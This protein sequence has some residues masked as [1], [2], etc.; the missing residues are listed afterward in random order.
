MR[1]KADFLK[2]K[3]T[4]CLTENHK[5]IV[6]LCS[7]GVELCGKHGYFHIAKRHVKFSVELFKES[8]RMYVEVRTRDCSMVEGLL[9]VLKCKVLAESLTQTSHKGTVCMHVFKVF[10][11]MARI[12]NHISKITIYYK[13]TECCICSL[14]ENM[15]LCVACG[16]IFCGRKRHNILGNEHGYK[17][18]E[19]TEHSLFIGLD[20]FDPKQLSIAAFC[21]FCGIFITNEI[22]NE[23]FSC[24]YVVNDECYTCHSQQ[25]EDER[26]HKRIDSCK[27][28]RK[29]SRMLKTENEKRHPG[30]VLAVIHAI[31]YCILNVG[32]MH[33]F[34]DLVIRDKNH[35]F[36]NAFNEILAKMLSM[37]ALGQNKYVFVD[38]IEELVNSSYDRAGED[39]HMDA[40]RFFRNFISLL[41]RLE[42]PENPSKSIAG[43]FS[44]LV[45]SLITCG[46]CK[47]KWERSEKVS[48]LYLKPRQTV[49]EYFSIKQ[50]DTE[51][52]CGAKTKTITSYLANIPSIITI[53]LKRPSNSIL[54]DNVDHRIEREIHVPYRESDTR[55]DPISAREE[56]YHTKPLNKSEDFM[57]E[58]SL[59]NS[60]LIPL[61]IFEKMKSFFDKVP[62]TTHH[63]NTNP[64][65]KKKT[66]FLNYRI[67]ASVVH[68]NN[69]DNGYYFAQILDEREPSKNHTLDLESVLWNSFIDGVILRLP[70]FKE[71]SI[72][73]FYVLSNV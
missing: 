67:R 10:K 7:C 40:A 9:E 63:Q 24:R 62:Q 68:Q 19:E 13:N 71:D 35:E 53:R 58:E 61:E 2:R 27:C 69:I 32:S 17:H 43:L 44:I 49:S 60:E 47:E 29:Y 39:V 66:S 54:G 65:G 57:N 41:K 23:I 50:L 46:E 1:F 4:Q 59:F 34:N 36:Q 33:I 26:E 6:E 37:H 38:H 14:Q 48:I 55:N 30:Y 22:V 72:L 20:M 73:L 11:E 5:S 56:E 18:F 3:C 70:L 51:C 16:L 15:W 64:N 8:N 12:N 42:K 28:G 52:K 31:S 25:I 21:S 45:K